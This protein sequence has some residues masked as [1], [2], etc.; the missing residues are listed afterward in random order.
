MSYIKSSKHRLQP[1]ALNQAVA[2]ALLIPAAASHATELDAA[3]EQVLPRVV[4][5]GSAENDF[6]ADKAASPK[7][8]QPLVDT[9]QT[10][11][12][13]KKELIEQ[14]GAVTLTEALRNTP[15]VGAFF[16]GE[17]GSTNTGDAIN[18]RGFDTSSSIFVDGVRDVGSV[19]RDVFNIEQIDVLKGPAG[20]DT[21]RGAP[22]GSVNLVSKTANL[23][24]AVTAT[25][26]AGSAGY[27]RAT[28]DVNRA[29]DADKGS[30]V[31]LNAMAQDGG[32]PGRDLVHNRRWAVAPSLSL[33]L[34]GPTRVY[35]NYLH[36]DQH[37]RPDGGVPTVGLPGYTSPD[38]ARAFIGRAAMVEPSNFYG[39]RSDFDDVR[40]DML[41]AR[42][43]QALG[44]GFKLFNTTRYGRTE[45]FYVLTSFIASSAN[46]S[47][48]NPADPSTWTVARSSRTVKDQRNSILT[49]QTA[50]AMETKTGAVA[51]ALVAGLELSREK[52]DNLSYANLGTMPAFGLY[53]P[54]ADDPVTNRTMTPNGVFNDGRTDT[55]SA[56]LFDTAKF[57]ERWQLSGGVRVDRHDTDYS[58]AALSTA[59]SHPKLPVGTL[60]RSDLNVADTLVNLKLAALYKPSATSSVYALAATSE[61]PPG[62]STMVLSANANNAANPIYDAQKTRNLEI[63]GKWD[64]LKQKLAFT[65]ALYRTD[66]RNELEQDPVDLQYYQTGKK[67]VEGVEIGVTGQVARGWLV[68]AGYTRMRT[69]VTAGRS[70]TA[71]GNSALA[72][73]PKQA[74]TAWTAYT[75]PGGLK[76]GGGARFV[77]RLWRGTDGAIGTPAYADSYWVADAMAS[78]PVTKNVDLQLNLYNLTDERYVAAINKSGYR[79]SPGAPRS[80]TLSAVFRF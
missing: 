9:P 26:A 5:Q 17:N 31:R 8:T 27:K 12:V 71:A 56:Y 69:E 4:V 22:T 76:F 19:S 66:V 52:Q 61:L 29:L 59:T 47:T 73:T 64:L 28:V 49:N 24:D 13:I 30:A 32:V 72:Y 21:G 63:G 54:N 25:V 60:V 42:V 1:S 44:D 57:G 33:G 67:R 11:T 58:G 50:L 53:R 34:N 23:E 41:T 39:A 2:L 48:P 35:L 7:Y 51:H 15:G 16:L 43:E 40:A 18:M 78:Y 62:G 80:A 65:A 45:Q 36:V 75:L 38:P 20:T 79:Y 46:F 70:A 74:F 55:V 10:V 68:S 77:D 6:K 37:N 3:K 14:Q